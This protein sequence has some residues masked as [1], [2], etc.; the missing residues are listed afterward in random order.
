MPEYACAN[1][2]TPTDGC[3]YCI[4]VSRQYASS[5][6]KPDEQ[7]VERIKNI[8]DMIVAHN[9]LVPKGGNRLMV[10]SH[11]WHCCCMT[12]WYEHTRYLGD[13]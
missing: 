3:E 9:K 8:K 7:A 5:S 10:D 1:H 4:K 2:Y 12:C 11:S 6:Y 13:E